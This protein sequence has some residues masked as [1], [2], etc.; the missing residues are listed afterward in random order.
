MGIGMGIGIGGWGNKKSDE[1][2]INSD[3][4]VQ[5]AMDKHCG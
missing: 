5:R 2:W 4:V 3:T 1:Q